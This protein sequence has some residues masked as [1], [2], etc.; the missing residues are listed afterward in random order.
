MSFYTFELAIKLVKKVMLED[1]MKLDMDILKY[2]INKQDV[3]N[4][5]G[6]IISTLAPHKPKVPIKKI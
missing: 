5:Q 6:E 1:L 2:L 4:K 3:I